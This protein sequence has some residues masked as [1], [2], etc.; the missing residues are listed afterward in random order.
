MRSR[1]LWSAT[2][3][4]FSQLRPALP[5]RCA[6]SETT[7][8]TTI[9]LLRT[10]ETFDS[11]NYTL[12]PICPQCI[13]AL[14]TAAGQAAAPVSAAISAETIKQVLAA[15]LGLEGADEVLSEL[16][17]AGVEEDTHGND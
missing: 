12:Q 13:A 1:A 7:R 3:L 10:I 16:R 6:E 15:R 11:S 14:A 4:L 17:A 9:A 5:N 8:P 2:T